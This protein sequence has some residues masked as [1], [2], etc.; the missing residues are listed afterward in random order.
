METQCYL[1]L[2][3]ERNCTMIPL[4]GVG[5]GYRA[6]GGKQKKLGPQKTLKRGQKLPPTHATVQ[7]SFESPR[8]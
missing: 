3:Q 5:H 1:F 2:E 8:M 7:T 6:G 4:L